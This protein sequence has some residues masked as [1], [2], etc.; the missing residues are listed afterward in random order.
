VTTNFVE[1]PVAL[2][3]VTFRLTPL[4]Q[5]VVR[6]LAARARDVVELTYASEVMLAVRVLLFGLRSEI[7]LRD[8]AMLVELRSRGVHIMMPL[9]PSPVMA[10][11]QDSRQACTSKCGRINYSLG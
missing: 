1:L 4:Q 7:L 8:L 11:T 3:T 5:A 6:S 10:M 2:G 9:S